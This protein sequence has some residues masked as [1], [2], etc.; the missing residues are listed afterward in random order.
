MNPANIS[1]QHLLLGGLESVY[2][3]MYNQTMGAIKKHMLY[4]PMVPGD[5]DILF[6][7]SLLVYG[8][9]QLDMPMLNH[10]VEHLTCFIGGMVGMGAKIFEREGDLEMAK[11][12]TDGCVWAYE[13][14]ASGIMPEGGMLMPCDDL[15]QCTWNQTEYHL[16]LDPQGV[17]RDLGVLA[18][19]KNKAIREEEE[20]RERVELER[21]K[22]SD[23]QLVAKIK[24]EQEAEALKAGDPVHTTLR[25][26]NSTASLHEDAEAFLQKR[27]SG[28]AFSDA[29]ETSLDKGKPSSFPKTTIEDI[30]YEKKAKQTEAE[31]QSVASSGRQA[32]KPLLA[33]KLEATPEYDPSLPPTHEE[34]VASRIRQEA[35]PPGYLGIRSRQYILRYVSIPVLSLSLEC[36]LI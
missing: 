32:E 19:K 16:K 11:R 23:D 18:Y 26:T 7:G 8:S 1:Q 34:Y 35:L 28:Q 20:E 14:T 12:L 10:E 27:Q 2:S 5:Q 21:A 9:L 24:A 4:R 15:E 31:L 33:P 25:R 30:S 6:T 29:L 22:A 36:E 3:K 13:A 17:E